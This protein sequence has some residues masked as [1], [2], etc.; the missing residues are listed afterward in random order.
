M[1]QLKV[2]ALIA[3]NMKNLGSQQIA[4]AKS[5]V[6]ANPPKRNPLECIDG[7]MPDCAGPLRM[8]SYKD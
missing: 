4:A 8:I 3:K 6:H 5:N 1:T 2:D 7:L